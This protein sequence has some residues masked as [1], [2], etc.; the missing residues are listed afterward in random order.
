[1]CVWIRVRERKYAQ[2]YIY[3]VNHTTQQSVFKTIFH[4]WK[5]YANFKYYQPETEKTRH[6]SE[7]RNDRSDISRI[8]C[9]GDNSQNF[10]IL[11]F[12]VFSFNVPEI[13]RKLI[14]MHFPWVLFLNNG[15]F[16]LASGGAVLLLTPDNLKVNSFW[17]RRRE[18]NNNGKCNTIF[19]NTSWPINIH[20]GRAAVYKGFPPVHISWTHFPQ[21]T[22]LTLNWWKTRFYCVSV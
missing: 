15:I 9:P 5:M 7:V 18:K 6:G 1:M 14:K 10:V 17:R 20:Q 13:R 12:V 8:E 3:A 11:F 4:L 19:T 16:S 2:A 21:K 22:I